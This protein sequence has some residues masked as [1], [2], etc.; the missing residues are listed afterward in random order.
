MNLEILKVFGRV[1][2]LAGLALG[3]QKTWIAKNNEGDGTRPENDSYH[4][5][6]EKSKGLNACESRERIEV[7]MSATNVRPFRVCVRLWG[8]QSDCGRQTQTVPFER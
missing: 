2:G 6:R 5:R 4:A 1:A 7:T 8:R 3:V